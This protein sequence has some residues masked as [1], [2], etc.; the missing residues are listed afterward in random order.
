LTAFAAQAAEKLKKRLP[1]EQLE[2]TAAAIMVK[3][4][5][6]DDPRVAKNPRGA[7]DIWY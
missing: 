4:A 3:G 7:E 6:P 2:K 1:K 5:M